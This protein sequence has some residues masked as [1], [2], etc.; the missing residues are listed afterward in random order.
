L[1]LSAS[2]LY[3]LDEIEKPERHPEAI[4]RLRRRRGVPLF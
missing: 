1:F 2:G 3:R 4:Q